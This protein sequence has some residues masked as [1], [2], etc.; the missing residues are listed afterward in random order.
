LINLSE[1]QSI[2]VHAESKMQPI[3]KEIDLPTEEQLVANLREFGRISDPIARYLAAFETGEFIHP[4]GRKDPLGT[5]RLTPS[6]VGLLSH[7][8]RDCQAS[9]SIEIGFGMGSSATGILATRSSTKRPF[10]HVVFDPFGLPNG[11]GQIVKDYLSKTFGPSFKAIPKRSEIG[12]AQLIAERGYEV[13]ELIFIDGGHRFDNVIVD[14]VLSDHLLCVGGH[15]V[16]DDANFPAI[17]TTVNYIKVNRP[18]YNVDFS[19]PNT[20]IL[21]KV[22]RDK[23]DW[24][25]FAPFHVPNRHDWQPRVDVG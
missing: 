22:G 3:I 8:S 4:D 5:V 11:R 21:R 19:I 1:Y 24:C 23:R 7:L 18:D 13:S 9:L 20:A 14:F 15:I 17:E 25:T 10:E 2:N 16:L 12:L 6:Q